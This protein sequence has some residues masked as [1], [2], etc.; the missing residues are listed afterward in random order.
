MSPRIA[1]KLEDIYLYNVM[2][3]LIGY[4]KI[5]AKGIIMSRHAKRCIG[6]TI[7]FFAVWVNSTYAETLP[8]AIE[9]Y[10]TATQSKDID[11]YMNC[12]AD[13]PT[14]IDVSRTFKGK[15]TIRQWA[16]REVIPNGDQFKH[17][18]ILEQK[19]NYAKTLVKWMVWNAHYHYW[20][21]DSGKITKMSLQ[22]AD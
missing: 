7:L 4:S 12:F 14:M 22:Y 15:E 2:V 8:A 13:G 17:R 10:R 11:A 5:I 21:D 6:L 1:F 18:E 3:E 19:E 9:C 16:L 20:W